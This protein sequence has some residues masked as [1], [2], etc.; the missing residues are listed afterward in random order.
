MHRPRR[1]R[2]LIVA[3]AATLFFA[4]GTGCSSCVKDEPAPSSGT[5]PDMKVNPKVGFVNQKLQPRIGEDGAILY[6]PTDSGSD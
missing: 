5:V 3:A 6:P 4:N 2:Q 1:R